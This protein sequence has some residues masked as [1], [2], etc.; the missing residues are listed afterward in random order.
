MAD[1]SSSVSDSE[2]EGSMISST[3]TG[4]G[5]HHEEGP[6]KSEEEKEMAKFAKRESRRVRAWKYSTVFTILFTATVVTTGTFVVLNITEERDF[7]SSV[8]KT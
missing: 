1:N 3:G 2:I 7:E 6:K 5:N 8:S 4:P